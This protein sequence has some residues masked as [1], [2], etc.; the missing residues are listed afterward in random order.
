MLITSVWHTYLESHLEKNKDRS[1]M[2]FE[3]LS[4]ARLFPGYGLLSSDQ[5]INFSCIFI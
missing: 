2:K 4:I 3:M 5:D 1:V